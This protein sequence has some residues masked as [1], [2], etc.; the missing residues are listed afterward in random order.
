[1]TKRKKKCSKHFKDLI[2][3]NLAEKLTTITILTP[4][5]SLLQS[6]Y[7]YCNYM[8]DIQKTWYKEVESEIF[9]KLLE[10]IYLLAAFI[11]SQFKIYNHHY[12]FLYNYLQIIFIMLM[13]YIVYVN[14]LQNA[15]FNQLRLHKDVY[16]NRIWFIDNMLFLI[17][18]IITMQK[19]PAAIKLWSPWRQ[20]LKPSKV[21]KTLTSSFILEDKYKFFFLINKNQSES[22]LFS[23]NLLNY[24]SNSNGYRQKMFNRGFVSIFSVLVF[25]KTLYY[26]IASS[27]TCFFL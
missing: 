12:L 1:M 20:N 6:N 3:P 25:S 17:V 21:C 26:D 9:I 14:P 19:R 15:R 5:K 2:R 7:S 24:L 27:G 10:G 16:N 18:L 13:V 22:N 8:N 23:L 11:F 4:K